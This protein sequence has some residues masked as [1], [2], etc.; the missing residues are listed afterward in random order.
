M[1][2]RITTFFDRTARHKRITWVSRAFALL[3]LVWVFSV[4][5]Q[6]Q[7]VNLSFDAPG[8]VDV[9]ETFIV[10]AQASFTNNPDFNG[11]QLEI[12]FDESELTLESVVQSDDFMNAQPLP[13]LDLNNPGQILIA[14]GAS[15]GGGANPQVGT[16]DLVTMTFTAN[17]VATPTS[18]S[19]GNSTDITQ[20]GG[21]SI[22]GSTAGVEIDILEE[23]VVNAPPEA[24]FSAN[25]MSGTAP[26]S[27]SF[28]ASASSDS[29]GTIAN[30]SWDFDDGNGASGATPSNTFVN[31]GTYVVTLTVTDDDN[32]TDTD[33]KTIT[34][35]DPVADN[36]APVITNIASQSAE[37]GET[38]NISITASDSDDDDID[39]SIVLQQGSNTVPA[40]AYSFTD[41]GNGTADFT[42]NTQVGDA[43]NYTATVIA[44]DGE[45]NDTEVFQI[46][47]SEQVVN[48]PGQVDFILVSDTDPVEVGETFTVIA[49]ASFTN[50]P[51]FN[52]TQLEINYDDAVLNLASYTLTSNY[53]SAQPVGLLNS[54]SPGQI[55]V[56][57]GF[58]LG[59]GTNP[60]Q[61]TMDLVVME[62]TAQQ[63]AGST[64]ISFGNSTDATQQGGASI[65]DDITDETVQVI[66]GQNQNSAPAI[67]NI[68]DQDVVE[69]DQIS[70]NISANDADDDPIS[71][72]IAIQDG[73]NTVPASV[74]TFT[75]NGNGTADFQWNT[76]AGDA[77][78]YT[79]TVTAD[80]GQDTDTESFDITIQEDN[81]GADSKVTVLLNP[82]DAVVAQGQTF[83]VS[84]ELDI[85]GAVNLNG[86]QLFIDF[87]PTLLQVNAINRPQ[88]SLD[89]LPQLLLNNFDNAA[90]EINF[91]AGTLDLNNFAGDFTLFEV[92]F[93][94]SSSATGISDLIIAEDLPR[95][96]QF[97]MPGGGAITQMLMDGSVEV[98]D[99][100]D[101]DEVGPAIEEVSINNPSN[102]GS[103]GSFVL[104]FQ[105][106]PNG[107]YDIEY[108]GGVFTNITVQN[109][110]ATIS[111]APG[112][113]N[114]LELTIGICTSD[115]DI[116][117]TINE[118]AKPVLSLLS[119]NDPVSCGS[120]GSIVLGSNNVPDGTYVVSYD[121]GFFNNVVFSN[122]QATIEAEA[123]NYDNLNI[124]INGCTSE[125]DLDVQLSDPGTP[126]IAIGSNGQNPTTCEGNNGAIE[127]TGLLPNESYTVS[128]MKNGGGLSTRQETADAQGNILI[129]NLGAG[130][131]TGI[132]AARV[133]C[134]SNSLNA[135]LSD[136]ASPQIAL[137]QVI[138]PSNG[139]SNGSIQITNLIPNATYELN[140][141]INGMA[142]QP[143]TVQASNTGNYVISGLSS[144]NYTVFVTRFECVSNTVMQILQ[145]PSQAPSVDLA[146]LPSDSEVGIGETF[147][148]DLI[149][150]PMNTPEISGL[151]VYLN[152][153]EAFLQAT[154]II[155]QADNLFS[156]EL[157]NDISTAGEVDYSVVTLNPSVFDEPFTLFTLELTALQPINLT[158]IDFSFSTDQGNV[159]LTEATTPPN[160]ANILGDTEGADITIL[161]NAIVSGQV[162][163]QGRSTHAAND[164][165]VKFYEAGTNNQVGPDYPVITN[166]SGNF[167][168]SNIMPGNY[169][170]YVKKS[171]F[172]QRVSENVTLFGGNNPLII[173]DTLLA[174]D[175]NNDN[176]VTLPDFTIYSNA[177]A[178]AFGDANFDSRVDFNDDGLIT[179]PDF[180][181]LASN[182]TKVGDAPEE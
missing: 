43:G 34:V 14:R 81:S 75:D 160:G 36:V 118:P 93:T 22:I 86:T 80:D 127:I 57:R 24:L 50:N 112:S 66:E 133:G 64:A 91:A 155:P 26:L 51:D 132:N 54:S 49:Q 30:Y 166:S 87:D 151:S 55:L 142:Q 16:M 25:P 176:V 102:C 178:T 116:D 27:V 163:M 88:E 164:I 79:A 161:E 115:E 45:D 169:D 46:N 38:I 96:T 72:S 94:A 182:F 40:S 106:V 5:G 28:D 140:V 62:F 39:L 111:A 23:T 121:G 33:T 167:T 123:G 144:G 156:L 60:Q 29:D 35:S 168:I 113:Y 32:A 13:L 148:L 172:L 77:G 104:S 120:E 10:I 124:T 101:C 107:T 47:L 126:F 174:G 68:Q 17:E 71:L 145:D 103:D 110:L 73:G 1:S 165:V 119:A 122:G 135:V 177:F 128:F 108:D 179:L 109:G 158:S 90:G 181:L 61:G 65:L 117:V 12:N 146:L 129:D 114:N 175:A 95:E 67:A 105:N 137:G 9:G 83:T 152:Y 100:P 21:G 56:A 173:F 159:R 70:L 53:T 147:T 74:Y 4:S 76:S 52:G 48:E 20:Q 84:V 138:Q 59:A 42:W 171:N 131:Y 170:I 44:T 8:S 149:V 3:A 98:Q 143:A 63:V 58:S 69:G 78:S 162:N 139:S 150:Q 41:N 6:A 134:I 7:T 2:D 154:Q 97:T 11:T 19:Y 153:D 85:E 180:T 157:A 82:D 18:I 125:E 31:A 92:S 130:E 15:L 136:P 89:A 99:A 37:E 141:S